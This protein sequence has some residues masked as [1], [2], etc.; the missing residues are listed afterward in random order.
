MR[1]TLPSAQG[2][3]GLGLVIL[4]AL[5]CRHA[6]P[7]PVAPGDPIPAEPDIAL[8]GYEQEC[9]QLVAAITAY[10]TCPHA[11]AEMHA[12]SVRVAEIAQ[13]AFEAGKK[14]QPDPQS[15]RVMALACHKA[16]VSMQNAIVRCQNGPRP[17][18]D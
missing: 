7:P 17:K 5:S 3:K 10:G 9:D 2:R 11:D 14:G 1:R 6:A 8:A 4:A 18:A 15:Q 16:T 13:Q 12:W